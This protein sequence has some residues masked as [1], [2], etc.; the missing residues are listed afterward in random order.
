MLLVLGAVTGDRLVAELGELDPD[1]LGGDPVG[2]VADDG[3]VPT[4]GRQS[5]RSGGDLRPQGEGPLHGNRQVA[6][7]SEHGG[8]LGGG[9]AEGVGEGGGEQEA[10]RDLSVERLGGGHAHLD[11]AAVGRVQ[12]AV[13]PIGEIAVASVHDGDH[14]SAASPHQVHGAV[15]VGGGA[16]LADRHDEGVLHRR[17]EVEARQLGGQHGVDAQVG[18]GGEGRQPLGEGAGGHGGGALTDGHHPSD[19][20]V[21]QP[22]SDRGREHVVTQR[23]LELAVDLDELAPQGLAERPRRLPDLLEQEVGS[24]A[25]I[26]V[27]RGD[28]RGGQLGG[29]HGQR[30]PVVGP[31]FDALEPARSVAVQAHDLTPRGRVGRI[32]GHLTVEAQVGV[33]L[34]DDAVGLAGHDVGIL[35]QTDVQGLTTPAQREEEVVRRLGGAGGDGHRS[36][37]LV[38]RPPEGLDDL[39]AVGHRRDARVG[40]TLA[41]VVISS[42]IRS[43]SLALRSAKLSTSPLSTAVT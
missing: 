39:G 6:D 5:G 3:P 31:A 28:L 32:G 43:A 33:G 27:A 35:G 14:V 34:L 21:G 17:G 19:A 16:G 37:E 29:R 10:G 30:G 8:P 7:A 42:A 40:I 4:G 18:S 36:L 38:D 9:R 41:S 24:I 2:A 13:G 25:P 20:P 23:D 1:L 11:V 26:D 15:G 22:G 12:H